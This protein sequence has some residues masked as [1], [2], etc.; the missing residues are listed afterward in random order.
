[1]GNGRRFG[2]PPRLRHDGI[3]CNDSRACS[4][5]PHVQFRETLMNTRT[6]AII[7]LAIAVIVLIILLT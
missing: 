2:A 5:A 7:A 3:G 1:M 4:G 6:I